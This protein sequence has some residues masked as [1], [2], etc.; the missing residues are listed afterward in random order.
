MPD[1]KSPK[2][3]VIDWNPNAQ[4]GQRPAGGTNRTKLFGAVAVVAILVAIAAVGISWRSIQQAPAVG[5]QLTAQEEQE[6][7]FKSRSRAE[8]AYETASQSLGAA[9]N[10]PVNHEGLLQEIA[11]VEKAFLLAE[12][13]LQNGDYAEASVALERVIAATEEFTETV[14]M[15]RNANKRYDD[16]YARLRANERYKSF[17]E[18]DYDVAFTSIGEGRHLLEAGSFR[19][20]W[21]AFDEAS[22]TLDRF[23]AEKDAYVRDNLR[24]GQ[25]ALKNGDR[26]AAETA[27]QNALTYDNGNEAGIRGL[28]RAENASRVFELLTKARV[29]EDNLDF[30]VAIASYDEAFALDEFNATAQQGA[31]RAR[32]DQKEALFDGF[33]SDAESAAAADDW[34][35]V[36]ASYEQALEV[37][38]KRTDIEDAL[39]NAHEEY[40]AALVHNTLAEAYDLEREYK[41]DEARFAY[42][43]LLDLEPDYEEAIEGLIR[44]GRT[45]RALLEYEKL[46]E[47]SEQHLMASDFQASIRAFNQAMQTKPGYLEIS[48]EAQEMRRVLELNSTPVNITFVSDTKTWVS[49]TNFRM[50]GKIKEESVSLPPGDYEVIG[51][52]KNFQDVMLLL[53]VRPQMSTNVVSV[54]CK[55]R[56]DS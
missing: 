28:A 37:Y 52:R 44:V 18:E 23:E 42:E 41:W 9:R 35:T 22:D 19:A 24:A 56:A 16:L 32:A 49:I 4:Q 38:P 3:Q 20:A 50:L 12:T 54:I 29:A 6:L 27:F 15:Q 1:Q 51:R 48:P 36:I 11:L 53:K 21:Q 5:T 33:I 14:E 7:A 40:H 45:V 10:L 34:S 13:R 26:L 17:S 8:L 30:D 39:E 25:M 46:L 2:H 55:T 47:L 43:R 31:A